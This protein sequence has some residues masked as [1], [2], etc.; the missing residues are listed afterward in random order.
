MGVIWCDGVTG[1]AHQK[2][3]VIQKIMVLSAG[4]WHSPGCAAAATPG[5]DLDIWR[6]S[7]E[8]LIEHLHKQSAVQVYSLVLAISKSGCQNKWELGASHARPNRKRSEVL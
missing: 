4:Q 5:F 7:P 1:E 6:K 8:N 2:W 3:R